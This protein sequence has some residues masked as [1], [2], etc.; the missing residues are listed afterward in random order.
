M[1]PG[2]RI[3]VLSDGTGNAASKVWR[4]N[5]WR[6]FELLDLTCS[7][8]VA[9]YDDGV[10]S[11]AFKPI[12]LLGGAFG[13]GL[14]RN[15][16]DLYK[17]VCRN[18][19][20]DAKIYAFGFSRGGFTVRVLVGLILEQG[21]VP[22]H[23]ES[24]L[25]ARARDAYRAFRRERFRSFLHIESVFRE[26]RDGFIRLLSRAAGRIPY[27]KNDNRVVPAVEFVGVWDTVA[28]YGLP[29]EEMTQG[30]SQWIWPLYLPERRLHPRVKRACHALALDDERTTFHPVLWTEEGESLPPPDGNGQRWVK[31]ERISQVWFAGVHSNVGGG[32]PD[33]ALAF[34]PLH[35]MMEEA[36]L[37]GL[38]FK[39]PPNTDPNAFL[40]VLSARDKDG[41][42]YDSRSGLAGYYRYGPRKI[43]SF[44]NV[45]LYGSDAV[46]ILLPKIHES[47]LAR[48]RSD[49]NAYAPIGLPANYAVVTLDGRILQ[50]EDNPFEKP[51]EATARAIEQETVWNWVWLRRIV[52]FATLAASFHLIAFW[53][54]HDR[55]P[56]HE[57]SSSFRLVSEFVRLV[58]SFL[59]QE[60]VK[61]WTNWYAANPG[62]LLIGALA[63]AILIWIGS[64]IEAHITDTMRLIWK[65]KAQQGT[66][67][68]SML[69]LALCRFRTSVAYEQSFGFMKR[70]V[71]PFASAVL[72]LW[73]GV[74]GTSHL[75]FNIMDSTGAFCRESDPQQLE[76]LDTKP[77]RASSP[78]VFDTSTA[79]HPTKIHVRAKVSYS[80]VIRVRSDSPWANDGFTTSPTGFGTAELPWRDR[81]VM[82]ATLPQRRVLF[83]RWFVPLARVGSTGTAEE[84]LDPRRVGDSYQAVFKPHRSGELFL[85]VNEAV[86]PLPW[87][88]D[89]FYRNNSGTA[90]IVIRRGS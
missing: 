37:R 87:I 21:L 8:Q 72:L 66:L 55:H 4:T 18:Y 78:I 58:E 54:F 20:P 45:R 90:E 39:A 52:Y 77:S 1:K 76:H 5:V 67:K 64:K 89:A 11:A 32:Y 75:L 42:Q 31:D 33:D 44:S 49:C 36:R 38:G 40:K 14:K 71:L 60:A 84:F 17:F 48:M 12:A 81:L 69:H 74:M 50:G 16:L 35:W 57:Y 29:I 7:G 30:V 24:D 82:L 26:L 80:A 10:G 63:L 83:R 51:V 27:D 70:Y 56:E 59:P 3:V 88:N 6:V 19:E 25:H 62:W 46:R 53:L 65:A 61:W 34:V 47:A 23:S 22:Y 73:L 68:S 85:Y 2:K 15:V 13:W 28:A 43:A 9:K 41:R 86:I 79:C